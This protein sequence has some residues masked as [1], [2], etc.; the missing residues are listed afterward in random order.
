MNQSNISTETCYE[1]MDG[2]KELNQMQS[3]LKTRSDKKWQE[4]RYDWESLSFLIC[5]LE[6]REVA[7][8]HFAI[9]RKGEQGQHL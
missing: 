1:Q 9:R 4:A 2:Q 5:F 3:L 8:A 7:S 6:S